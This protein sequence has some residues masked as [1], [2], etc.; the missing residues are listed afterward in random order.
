MLIKLLTAVVVIT[1]YSFGIGQYSIH[2]GMAGGPEKPFYLPR[3]IS[4]SPGQNHRYSCA[5]KMAQIQSSCSNILKCFLDP[6]TQLLC[7]DQVITISYAFELLMG[8]A[9]H[10]FN[11]DL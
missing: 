5:G 4:Q 8:H 2:D 11:A 9:I 3:I 7:A 10:S 6:L 1:D